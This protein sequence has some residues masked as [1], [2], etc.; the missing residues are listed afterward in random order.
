MQRDD[1][2]SDH[3]VGPEKKLTTRRESG[4]HVPYPR[5]HVPGGDPGADVATPCLPRGVLALSILPTMEVL[6]PTFLDSVLSVGLLRTLPY[7]LRLKVPTHESCET[8]SKQVGGAPI[9]STEL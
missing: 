6:V 2:T 7:L 1:V 5:L 8:E 9:T 3:T 4:L